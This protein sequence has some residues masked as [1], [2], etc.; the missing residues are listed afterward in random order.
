ME[1]GTL[2]AAA[3]LVWARL[4]LR[5]RAL[6][7]VRRQLGKDPAAS[8]RPPSSGDLETALL[9]GR[10]TL[11]VAQRLPFHCTCLVQAVALTAM[12]RRRGLAA[13]FR[14]GVRQSETGDSRITAHAWVEYDHTVVLDS[15]HH[16]RFVPLDNS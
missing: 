1:R 16:E 15:E 5:R 2:E 3:Y 6:A 9:L 11:A 4:A 10:T 8:P 12:L 14:L 7:E 13:D